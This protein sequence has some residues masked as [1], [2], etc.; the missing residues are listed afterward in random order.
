MIPPQVG[1]PPVAAENKHFIGIINFVVIALLAADYRREQIADGPVCYE[2]SGLN[3]LLRAPMAARCAAPT[4]AEVSF[5]YQY[6]RE[7]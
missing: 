7:R 2:R 5:R 6:T 4:P 1:N 3:G